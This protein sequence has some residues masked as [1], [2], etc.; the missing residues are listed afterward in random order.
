MHAHSQMFSAVQPS[1]PAPLAS[2]LGGGGLDEI[3]IE[4][5]IATGAAAHDGSTAVAIDVEA[6][7]Q[8]SLQQ[9]GADANHRAVVDRDRAG[10]LA[11][12]DDASSTG[13]GVSSP[14]DGVSSPG[15]ETTP[16]SVYSAGGTANSPRVYLPFVT[17]PTLQQLPSAAQQL[18]SAAAPTLQLPS[19]ATPQ[20]A[21]TAPA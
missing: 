13:D 1:G 9:P 14:G 20:A 19:I 11:S 4:S 16:W 12:V 5:E 7:P 6:S 18:P 2:F 17:T 21:E 15:D 8:Q 3:Q 10:D